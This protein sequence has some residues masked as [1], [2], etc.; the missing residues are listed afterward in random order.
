MTTCMK[1]VKILKVEGKLKTVITKDK[2]KAR[3]VK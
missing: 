2:K 3:D 1:E